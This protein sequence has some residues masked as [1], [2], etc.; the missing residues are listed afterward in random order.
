MMPAEPYTI[1]LIEDDEL[2]VE[3]MRRAIKRLKIGNRMLHASDGIVALEMLR[4]GDGRER[5]EGP[6]LVL[7]D[8]NMPRMN[9]IEFLQEI[10]KDERLRGMPIFVMSTSDRPQDIN[11]AY[12]AS[13]NGYVI[14]PFTMS[15]TCET[16]N[17]LS[18]YWNSIRYPSLD[19]PL[20]A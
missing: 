2:D 15:E 18:E 10:R 8:L 7:L 6:L 9:G 5:L 3:K 16:L 12:D 4:G 17:S 14:K 13:A 1:L 19:R 20:S 11:A